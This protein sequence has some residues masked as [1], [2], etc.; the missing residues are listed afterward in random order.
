MEPY[1][2]QADAA[3]TWCGDDTFHPGA[4][5]TLVDHILLRGFDDAA[6][7]VSRTYVEPV[8]FDLEDGSITANLSDHYGLNGTIKREAR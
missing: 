6:A 1:V 2:S 4:T 5:P 7:T 3:C 8:T